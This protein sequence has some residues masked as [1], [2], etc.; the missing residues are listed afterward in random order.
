MSIGTVTIDTAPT[1]MTVG[2]AETF[3]A[4]TDGDANV[5]WNWTKHSGPG[6]TTFSDQNSATTTI[7]VARG[8]DYIFK[9]TASSS[10]DGLTDGPSQDTNTASIQVTGPVMAVT[11]VGD[12]STAGDGTQDTVDT[13]ATS[14]S[15]LQVSYD[16]AGGTASNLV[17]KTSGTGYVEGESFTVDGDTGVT[18][19]IS[20][21]GAGP[22][23]AAAGLGA[24]T[25]SVT[26][27]G[28][29]TDHPYYGQGSGLGYYLDGAESP[30]IAISVGES[31]FFDQ[32][33]ST[34]TNHPLRIY[35]NADGSGTATGNQTIF[36]SPG[37]AGGL[38][39]WTPDTAGTYYYMCQNHQ[40]MGGVITVS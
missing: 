8:G 26:V 2:V 16:V 39:G 27:A 25:Y 7:S 29:T 33:D 34:N 23:A 17:L 40:Y 35:P 38:T 37:A 20:T 3:T 31:I 6:T 5:T 36:A 14:G 18:G 4:S 19:T 32:S 30:E 1:S 28:K 12:T 10:D 21:A 22:V 15:G 11:L 9:A 13:T 24:G